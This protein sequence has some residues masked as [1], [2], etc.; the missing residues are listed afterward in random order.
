MWNLNILKSNQQPELADFSIIT[1]EVDPHRGNDD[2]QVDIHDL[3]FHL[4]PEPFLQYFD[5][6]FVE[7]TFIFIRFV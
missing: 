4:K 3:E 6:R 5:H 1:F 2:L 7:F